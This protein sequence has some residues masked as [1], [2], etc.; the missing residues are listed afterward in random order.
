MQQ[1]PQ[2]IMPDGQS[3]IFCYTFCLKDTGKP[4]KSNSCNHRRQNPCCGQS[5]AD[6]VDAGSDLCRADKQEP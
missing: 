5:G 1:F 4:A 3:G 2:Y 6:L